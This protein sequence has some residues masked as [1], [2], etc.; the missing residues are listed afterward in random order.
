VVITI[1]GILIA[2]L[3]PAVQA[4]REA[5]RRGQCSN[6]FKQIGLG[7]HGYANAH[8]VLPPGDLNGGGYDCDYL[9]TLS[10]PQ[11]A[12]NFTALLFLLAFVEQNALYDQIDF[13]KAVSM[14]D[15]RNP[16]TP[17]CLTPTTG[18]QPAVTGRKK[19]DVYLCPSDEFTPGPYTNTGAQYYTENAYLTSY[20]LLYA[21]YGIR[22]TYEAYTGTKAAFGH[23]G[24]A[25]FQQFRDGTSSS[26]VMIETPLEKDAV[27]RGPYWAIYVGTG[28]IF[29]G[30]QFRT[31]NQPNSATD[32]RVRWGTPGSRHP[33]GCQGLLGDGSVR[34]LQQSIDWNLLKGL[35]TINGAELIGDY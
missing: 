15:G 19:L 27:L 11:E 26:L 18:T 13:K 12:R 10:P 32:T 34:F 23:N 6:N 3:L 2:L 24:A 17:A 35:E 9:N 28:A 30:S 31:I 1:I 14:S 25:R 29:S 16:S 33:G 7:L 22:Y 21:D 20:G 5:A 4:A 8:G